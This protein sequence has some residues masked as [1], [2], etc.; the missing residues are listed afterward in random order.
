MGDPDVLRAA[1]P[2]LAFLLRGMALVK[3]ALVL[4]GL[5]VLWWR[6]QWPLSTGTAVGYLS[7]AWLASGAAVMIWQLTFIAQAALL[8]H[9]GEIAL[10]V[11]AWGD[12]RDYTETR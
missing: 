5:G 9:V 7:G 2:E 1:D 11:L 3:G 10:L 4:A 12:Y 6:F 8:F